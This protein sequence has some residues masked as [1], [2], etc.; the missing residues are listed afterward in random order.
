MAIVAITRQAG[1]Q[2]DALGEAVAARLGYDLVRRT[3]L[4]RLAADIGGPDAWDQSPELR[5]RNPSFW[6]RLN[7][8]RQRHVGVLRSVVVQLAERD[9]VVIV[10]LGAGQ[11]LGQLHQVLRLLVIAPPKVRLAR[12]MDS[13]FEETPGPLS[14]EQAQELVRRRDRETIGYMRYLFHIDWLE[15]QHWDL[16]INTGRFSVGQASELIAAM[17]EG[18]LAEP[19]AADRERLGN[20]ALACR[21]ESTLLRDPSIWING[22]KVRADD[23]HVTIEGDVMADDDADPIETAQGI[24]RAVPGVTSVVAEL[25]LQPPPRLTF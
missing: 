8:D 9:R 13:G 16:V 3:D 2:G 4:L 14:H 19:T 7:D 1:S 23:G 22:L 20:M 18:G 25:R 21:V 5:E 17:V 10:G 6:E 15:P 12:V 11:L 24:A